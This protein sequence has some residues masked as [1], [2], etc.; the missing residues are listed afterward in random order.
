MRLI[1]FSVSNYRSFLDE[2]TVDFN[3][4]SKNVNAFFGPNGS[5]KSNLF[6]AMN[7]YKNF[8]RNST[9]YQAKQ[10]G[11]TPFVFNTASANLPTKFRAE[12]QTDSAIYYYGFS[13]KEGLIRNETLKRKSVD[14]LSSYKTLYTRS[15]INRNRFQ[16]E[17]FT[18]LLLKA[19]RDDS[20][21]LTKAWENNNEHALG[22]FKWLE[23][24][25]FMA[26][27]QPVNETAKR[28]IEDSKFK[29]KV[30]DLMRRADLYIQ[31]LSVSEVNMPDDIF[32]SL[33]ITDD[34]KSTINR[35]GYNVMT[36]HLMYDENGNVVQAVPLAMNGNESTG[37]VR[38]FTL[39][40]PII[41]TLDKGNILYID[42]FETNLHPKECAFLVDLFE[43]KNNKNGA[44]LIINTHS[45]QLLNKLGRN[46]I[47]LVGKNSREET[48]ISKIAKNIRT[49]DKALEKKY[50]QGMFGA[51]PNIKWS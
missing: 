38:I 51:T 1:S 39:A 10:M 41:D 9:S 43:S 47:H 49:D 6:H 45:T 31:D 25:Q 50:I 2:Q 48:V 20:L 27:D 42:E 17:G 40:F 28:I 44:Q 30:L 5:G 33:P 18:T 15:S 32:N 34:V 36:T 16:N 35:V 29:A 37:T 4:D 24:F 22:V 12:M 8:I 3:L 26:G 7:F 19:T 11:Y 14:G 13:I 21:V 46:N 23:H